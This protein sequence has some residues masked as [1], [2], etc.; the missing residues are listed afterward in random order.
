M[1]STFTLNS[2]A[3]QGRYLQLS[4]TQTK[5]VATNKSKISW[6]LSSIGGSS[7][8]YSTGATTVYIN[9]VQVYYKARVDWD[10]KVFPA[11]KGSVSG[12]TYVDHDSKGK[13]S[14]PVSLTT[15]IYVGSSSAT[16]T[17]GTWTLDDIP[18]QATITSAP[19]FTSNGNPPTIKY[20]NPAGNNV[21]K[22]EICIADNRAW[23]GYVPYREIDKNGTSYTFTADDIETL[24][25][26]AGKNLNV[27]FVIR[28]TINGTVLH[29]YEPSVFTMV[30][31]ATTKPT[32]TMTVALNNSNLPSTFANMYIQGKSRLDIAITAQGKYGASI[33]S[34]YASVDSVVYYNS[35]FT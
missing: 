28:T 31:D 12:V 21:S 13:K 33:S 1:A 2:S 24:K 30:E 20:S 18:R 8:Y 4:C 16:T 9:G 11:A 7:N 19:N 27:T 5:D 3:Y 10:D 35:S 25:S 15:A 17:S 22:L 32:V 34:Y 26:K 29:S 6:T 14:I 23:E